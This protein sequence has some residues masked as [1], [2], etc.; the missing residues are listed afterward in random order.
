MRS[1]FTYNSDLIAGSLMVRESRII[2]D[3]LLKH[4]SL[5]QWHHA[6]ELDNQLQKRTPATAKRNAQAIRKRLECLDEEYWHLLQE[7][8]DELA[9]QL[10]LVATLERNLL[11]LEFME[12]V[13]AEAY[14][15]QMDKLQRYQW[16]EF[17]SEREARDEVISLW[18]ESSRKKMGQVVFRILAEVGYLE[19]SRS[20]KLQPLIVR[21]E[22]RQLLLD[23]QRHRLL[24]CLEMKQ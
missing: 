9:T 24:R 10:S 5:E 2:A 7:G 14:L 8:D 23:K 17:L 22:L 6:I 16:E 19:S 4:V 13:V 20:L 3:L 18:M 1:E 15:T 12:A 21:G 11:L